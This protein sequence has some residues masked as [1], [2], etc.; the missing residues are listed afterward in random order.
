MKV[1]VKNTGL[2]TCSHTKDN[3]TC[4]TSSTCEIKCKEKKTEDRLVNITIKKK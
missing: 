2:F 4:I 3:T 1:K